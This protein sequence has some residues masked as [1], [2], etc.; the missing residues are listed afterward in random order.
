METL[1]EGGPVCRPIL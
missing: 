1:P